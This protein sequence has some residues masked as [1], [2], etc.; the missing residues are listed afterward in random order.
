M[1]AEGLFSLEFKYAR[2]QKAALGVGLASVEIDEIAWSANDLFSGQ[3]FGS[4][5]AKRSERPPK[6]HAYQ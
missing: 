1:V 3:S 4:S 2:C 5:P 6:L